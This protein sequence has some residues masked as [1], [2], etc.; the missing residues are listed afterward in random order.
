MVPPET[1]ICKRFKVSRPTV[2]IAISELVYQ[3][4]LERIPGKGTFVKHHK[5]KLVFANFQSAGESSKSSL[6]AI[7]EQYHKQAADIGVESVAIPYEQAEHELMLMTTAG[8]APDILSLIYLWIP[9]FAHQGALAPLDRWYTA[10]LS[11]QFYP[12]SLNAV[13]FDGHYY[14]FNWGNAPSILFY[15]NDIMETGSRVDPADCATY[16][17]LSEAF[18]RIHESFKGQIIPFAIPLNDNDEKSFLYSIYSFLH[19]FGGGV[20]DEAGEVKFHSGENIRAFEWLKDFVKR[21]HVDPTRD[22]VEIRRLFAFNKIACVIEGPWL[23]GIIPT[24]NRAYE[25][26][27][28]SIGFAVLPRSPAG[29]SVSVLWNHVLSISRQCQDPEKAI[30]FIKFVTADPGSA[31][32]HYRKTG[33]LPALKNHITDNPVYD[34]AF[35]K[36]LQEQMKTA[37]P[38]PFANSPL[39]M[40]SILFCARAAREI[41]IGDKDVATTLNHH[42]SI[43]KEIYRQ[44]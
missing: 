40:L 19:S 20:I 8:Q 23:R 5:E 9:I 16:D 37:I 12:Q 27:M 7:M 22:L 34:D 13:T 39:F 28:S 29:E 30:E 3:G 43:L 6:V 18:A 35:G 33:I 42:A 25:R 21:G 2:R 14:A 44:Y 24:L 32:I 31:E 38:I 11:Q 41:L 4:V 10:E 26:D 15:N 1:E 17:E 36:T